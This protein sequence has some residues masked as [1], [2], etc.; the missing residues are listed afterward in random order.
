M[1][2]QFKKQTILERIDE[3]FP[4]NKVSL[5]HTLNTKQYKTFKYFSYTSEHFKR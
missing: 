1:T 2:I 4:I 5:L 3:N